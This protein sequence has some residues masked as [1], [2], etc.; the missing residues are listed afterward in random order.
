M[1]ALASD[2]TLTVSNPRSTHFLDSD[3]SNRKIR[4]DSATNRFIIQVKALTDTDLESGQLSVLVKVNA[5]PTGMNKAENEKWET[6]IVHF[7]AYQARRILSELPERLQGKAAHLISQ[8]DPKSDLYK[9]FA[10]KYRELFNQYAQIYAGC[11][12]AVL[13]T[14][15]LPP[16]HVD[17]DFAQFEALDTPP[18]DVTFRKVDP[19]MD[20]KA[21]EEDA[22][23]AVRVHRFVLIGSSLYFKEHSEMDVFDVHG[24]S[25]EALRK[26]AS[27]L[28]TKK[29]DP[30]NSAESLE[31]YEL[32]EKYRIEHLK[33]LCLRG[34]SEEIV[35]QS[36]PANLTLPE[37]FNKT[38]SE[39]EPEEMI[40]TYKTTVLTIQ[41]LT[42]RLIRTI[43]IS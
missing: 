30:A 42:E 16:R 35:R 38:I 37:V 22:E 6:I 36:D 13:A 5:D 21:G 32:G 43:S 2:P 39:I 3:W 28:Y 29:V 18:K 10:N 11:R 41:R 23:D 24:V 9:L 7:A 12:A 20:H 1:A 27:Y 14:A 17:S 19:G 31:L 4:Y 25:I 8:I 34:A 26:F 33:G 15:D 40:Q